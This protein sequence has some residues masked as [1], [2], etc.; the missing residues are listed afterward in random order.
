MT[1]NKKCCLCGD[2]V[3]GWGHNPLPLKKGTCCGVCNDTKVIPAR[4]MLMMGGGK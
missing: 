4:L 3:T 1:K 2:V